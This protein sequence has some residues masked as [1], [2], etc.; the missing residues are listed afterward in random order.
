MWASETT[1]P[2]HEAVV[3]LPGWF[4]KCAVDVFEFHSHDDK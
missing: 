4:H 2:E 1:S 3:I